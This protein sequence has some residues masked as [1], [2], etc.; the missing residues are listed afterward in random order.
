MNGGPTTPAFERW[1]LDP[2]D[3]LVFGDGGQVPALMPRSTFLMPPQA[4][5]AGLVRTALLEAAGDFSAA[6]AR[7]ELAVRVR[8]PW[9]LEHPAGA[10][11][12]VLWA[13]APADV[14]LA[15][16][17][18]LP[19]HLLRPR[20]DDGVRWLPGAPPGL[21][22]VYLP[23]R[24]NGRKTER[25]PF[26][27]WPFEALVDWGLGADP[28]PLLEQKGLLARRRPLPV[29]PEHRVHVAIDPETQ[30]ALPEALFS[31]GGQRF[32]EEFQLAV[33]VHDGRP[34]DGRQPLRSPRLLVLGGEGRTV[35]CTTGGERV[36]PP[37]EEYEARLTAR[38]AAVAAED[39]LGLRLQLLTPG[40]FGGWQPA[41]PRALEGL[42]QAV[43]IGRHLAVSGWDLQHARPRAVRRLVP[44]GS[45][46]FLGPFTS[47]D[48]VIDL[49][50]QLWG[51]S[52][53][54]GQPG[55]PG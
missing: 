31:S 54:E 36:L 4:T 21:G 11:E 39:R 13:P 37:F 55:D 3:P 23:P 22:L 34:A 53:C 51:R 19:P 1:L 27:L 41:W 30:T 52:L 18:L 50:R 42:L 7:A 44:A 32:A 49:C 46:Y 24:E 8:G 45:V 48:Q 16:G 5:V 12:S 17:E 9:L 26:P 6:A 28:R 29:A 20:P 15:E 40:C 43:A 25:L 38:A 2:R 10:T 14:A 35:A 47:G 33:E